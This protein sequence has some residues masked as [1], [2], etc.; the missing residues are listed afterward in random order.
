[1]IYLV[2]CIEYLWDLIINYKMIRQLITI[3]FLILFAWLIFPTK[4]NGNVIEYW[5]VGG[6]GDNDFFASDEFNKSSLFQVK[7]LPIPWTEH[8]QK[9]LTAILS[10]TP[11][12]IISQFAPLK[13]W[14]SR[15]AL[16]PLDNFILNDNFDST[17]YFNSLWQEMNWNGKIYGIPINTTSY[18]FFYNK[19]IFDE[20]GIIK[21]PQTWEE[22]KII[23]KKIIKRDQKNN[24]TRIGYIPNY[25]NLRT[26]NVMAWQLGEKFVSNDKRTVQLNTNKVQKSFSW[27]R[28]YLQEIGLNDVLELMGTF[29]VADQHGF[30]SGKVSMMI[31]DSSFPNLIKTYNPNL[32]YGVIDIPSFQNKK[33]ISSSG[34]WWVGIPKNAKNPKKAWEFIKFLASTDFQIRYLKNSTETLFSANKEAAYHSE[35]FLDQNYKVFLDQIYKSRSP[36]IIPLAHDAFWREYSRAEERII[37]NY[38]TIEENL[39]EAEERIQLE[40]DKSYRYHDYVSQILMN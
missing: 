19:D 34:T 27:V 33:S 14:A 39:K 31:L 10:E 25:G 2:I 11:P 18:A 12:D 37:H 1:M 6:S 3:I 23:S 20:V 5:P 35:F 36:S 32:N 15:S 9:I 8:E 29:G 26:S 16:L 38:S 30:I 28:D 22:V 24:I 4:N 13:M 40:L 17:L 21:P 7:T